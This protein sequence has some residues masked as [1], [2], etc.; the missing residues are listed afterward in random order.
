MIKLKNDEYLLYLKLKNNMK[1]KYE[2]K[3]V[4]LLFMNYFIDIDGER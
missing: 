2:K 3:L 1:K 4:K